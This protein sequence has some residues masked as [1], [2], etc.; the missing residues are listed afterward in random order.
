MI[1]MLFVLSLSTSSSATSSCTRV[2]L[3]ISRTRIYLSH[4]HTNH[5]CEHTHAHMCIH[6][7]THTRTHTHAHYSVSF[8]VLP[9]KIWFSCELFWI[10][11]ISDRLGGNPTMQMGPNNHCCDQNSFKALQRKIEI[12]MYFFRKLQRQHWL[13]KAS[14]FILVHFVG[15]IKHRQI[16]A[17]Y[18]AL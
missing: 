6:T 7:R 2:S 10:V 3:P 17:S 5:H 8:S 9:A 15:R 4:L 14:S 11:E 18:Q 1:R 12:K 16:F 13:R